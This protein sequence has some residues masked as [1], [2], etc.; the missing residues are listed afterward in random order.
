MRD[1]AGPDALLA[2]EAH[3]RFTP[4]SAIRIGKR[5]EPFKPAWFEEPVT[6]RKYSIYR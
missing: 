2:I 3:S 5:L 1:A 6:A 4:S